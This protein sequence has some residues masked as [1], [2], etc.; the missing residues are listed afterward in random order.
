MCRSFGGRS[1]MNRYLNPETYERHLTTVDGPLAKF[2]GEVALEQL[3][4]ELDFVNEQP[5]GSYL[6][7]VD[8]WP[9]VLKDPRV[10]STI[11]DQCQLGQC[12]SRGQHV[13]KSTQLVASHDDL[14]YYFHGLKCGRFPKQC[15]GVHAALTG[16]EAYKARIWPW[17]FARRMAWGIV[18]LMKRKHW[19][20]RQAHYPTLPDDQVQCIACKRRWRSD[21]SSTPASAVNAG[22][23]M[24]RPQSMDARRVSATGTTHILTTPITLMGRLNAGGTL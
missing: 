17:A 4:D 22:I 1:R 21:H 11:F 18:R 8:P 10:C 15:K 19:K 20:P 2:A 3:A 23:P 14:L 24:Q 12:N 7:E 6:Y 9:S 5:T 13:K 16:Q